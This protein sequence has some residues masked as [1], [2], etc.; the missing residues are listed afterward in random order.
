MHWCVLV[1]EKYVSLSPKTQQTIYSIFTIHNVL[2]SKTI[3]HRKPLSTNALFNPFR[4]F[5]SNGS[6]GFLVGP[7]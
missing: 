2:G 4:E 6:S 3:D 1:I 7:P 5:S